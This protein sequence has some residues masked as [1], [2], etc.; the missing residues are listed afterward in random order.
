MHGGCGPGPCQDSSFGHRSAQGG[1]GLA[2]IA[3]M[4]IGE[5]IISRERT[6]CVKQP[7]LTK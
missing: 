1:P 5:N 4:E 7:K 3:R 6:K 2:K